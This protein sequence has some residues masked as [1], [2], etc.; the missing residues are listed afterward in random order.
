MIALFKPKRAA[1]DPTSSEVNDVPHLPKPPPTPRM[2]VSEI[3]FDLF[4]AKACQAVDILSN[5]LATVVNT[6][7][8]FVGFSLLSAAGAGVIPAVQ[9]IAM[10]AIHLG[11][12]SQDEEALSRSTKGGAG[13]GKLFGAF[14]LLQ[15]TGSMII[16]VCDNIPVLIDFN[17][18]HS[19]SYMELSTV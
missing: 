14:S 2:L 4:M 18:P 1:P 12:L 16:G 11:Q 15:A 9:S 13:L 7:P 6:A 17:Y 8:L 19:L 10:C 5:V 3:K